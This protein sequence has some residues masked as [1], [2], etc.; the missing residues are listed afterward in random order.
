MCSELYSSCLKQAYLNV[1]EIEPNLNKDFDRDLDHV[2]NQP[3]LLFYF[4]FLYYCC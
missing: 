1:K 4:R 3:L 2:D